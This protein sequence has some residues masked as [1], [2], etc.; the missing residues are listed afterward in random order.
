MINQ[1]Q[2]SQGFTLVEI[3]IVLTIVGILVAGSMTGL[4]ERQR[5]KYQLETEEKLAA[6]KEQLL[7]FALINKHLPCPDTNNDGLENRVSVAAGAECSAVYGGVPYLDI[8]I[9]EADALDAWN[10]PIRYAINQNTNSNAAIC[11][12]TQ[13]ASYFCN[14]LSNNRALFELDTPPTSGNDGLGNYSVC[15]E[16]ASSCSSATDDSDVLTK[17]A[18]V[19]LVAYGENGNPSVISS[20]PNCSAYSGASAE[21][22]DTDPYYH[23]KTLSNAEGSEFDDLIE[24]IT[25][26]EIKSIVLSPITVWKN[27]SLE[28]IPNPTYRNYSIGDGDYTPLVGDA[29]DDDSDPQNQDVLVVD[30]NISTA[31]DLGKGDD[32]VIVGN[33]LESELEYDNKTGEITDYGSQANLTTGPGNDTV[34]I[35]NDALSPVD[36]GTGDDK[37]VIGGELHELLTAGE[38]NDKV[39]I[40][41]G[42]SGTESS[43][44]TEVNDTTPQDVGAP[45]EYD[46]ENEAQTAI[47]NFNQHS[48]G[49]EEIT[50]NGNQEWWVLD[51]GYPQEN[52]NETIYLYRRLYY[53]EE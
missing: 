51:D 12:S 19:V 41:A 7:Q 36:L 27:I 17:I 53:F 20:S 49:S 46:S 18:S 26:Y 34:Y 43:A 9:K 48:E 28:G 4:G 16:S 14:N 35:V 40:Q 22:C 13:S 50:R 33:N 52:G 11:D 15:N 37:F 32:Y 6:I 25:G 44:S 5:V 30:Q 24:Y 2:T 47:E 3:A 1:K 45:V 8:G 21:N 42:Y 29:Q 39:W 38:G 31:L 23:Q 10:Y